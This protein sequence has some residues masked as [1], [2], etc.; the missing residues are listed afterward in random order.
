[1]RLKGLGYAWV[2]TD[3]EKE[4]GRSNLYAWAADEKFS[5]TFHSRAL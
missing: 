5:L 4:K 1:M 3:G 2:H